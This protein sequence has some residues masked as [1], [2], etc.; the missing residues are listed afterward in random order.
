[1]SMNGPLWAFLYTLYAT[2]DPPLLFSSFNSVI[3]FVHQL[4]MVVN[5]FLGFRIIKEY[6][7]PI[8]V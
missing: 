4:S 6:G 1:M 5:K 7:E 2:K 8:V 3:Q